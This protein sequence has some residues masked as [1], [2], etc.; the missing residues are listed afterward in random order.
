[1]LALNGATRIFRRFLPTLLRI[2]DYGPTGWQL[3]LD[4]AEAGL[5]L[6]SQ[7]VATA[8]IEALNELMLDCFAQMGGDGEGGSGEPAGEPVYQVM[9]KAAWDTYEDFAF[10]STGVESTSVSANF[11]RRA[12]TVSM[13]QNSELTEKTTLQ[14]MRSVDEIHTKAASAYNLS[15]TVQ[16]ARVVDRLMHHAF[17]FQSNHYD[18]ST[19][20]P[21]QSIGIS[22]MQRALDVARRGK[23]VQPPDY[24][25]EFDWQND[26]WVG[27]IL[28]CVRYLPHASKVA[29]IGEHL[30]RT[31]A[32]GLAPDGA[33]P[34]AH[35]VLKSL[36]GN[37]CDPT[38]SVGSQRQLH[39]LIPIVRVL[40]RCA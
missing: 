14:L 19:L 36:S 26:A 3:L 30:P 8:T 40:G 1:M 31:V 10:R 4:Y 18:P 38:G 21:T 12:T 11:A 33:L 23:A 6:G 16:A 34:L 7:E 22:W 27:L 25:A 13:K 15:A 29:Q 32:S 17:R 35:E 5:L 20:T 24:G 28:Y 39:V 9:W 2:S 37:F